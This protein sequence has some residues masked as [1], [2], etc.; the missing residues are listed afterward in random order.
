MW[1]ASHASICQG[2]V[3]KSSKKTKKHYTYFNRFQNLIKSYRA[4]EHGK[5]N[6]R[7]GNRPAKGSIYRTTRA[8]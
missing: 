6:E 1:W 7:H 8:L 5:A 2:R 4:R 3:I